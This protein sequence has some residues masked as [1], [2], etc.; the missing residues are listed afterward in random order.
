MDIALTGAAKATAHP[1]SKAEKRI[2]YS[3]LCAN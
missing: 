1:I 3:I 2:A